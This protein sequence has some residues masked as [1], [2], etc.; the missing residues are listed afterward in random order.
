MSDSLRA[1]LYREHLARAAVLDRRLSL[2][3]E[4]IAINRR[5]LNSLRKKD[6]AARVEGKQNTQANI[7]ELLE[8][9]VNGI[10]IKELAKAVGVSVAATRMAVS[11]LSRKNKV[12]L[13]GGVVRKVP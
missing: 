7:L 13:V 5:A 10:T 4:E 3:Q 2:L 8:G 12:A 11:R 9:K 6:S 1:I